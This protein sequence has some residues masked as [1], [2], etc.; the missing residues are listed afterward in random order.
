VAKTYHREQKTPW[1][2]G[3]MKGL[4]TW[5]MQKCRVSLAL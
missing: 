3:R 5:A 4:Q 1:T 2:T